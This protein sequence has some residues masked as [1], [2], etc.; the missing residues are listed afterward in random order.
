MLIT[1]V[2]HPVVLHAIDATPA[3]WRGDAVSSPLDR[4]RTAASSHPTHWLISTQ[5]AATRS[6]GTGWFY[7][8]AGACIF[9]LALFILFVVPCVI[10]DYYRLGL[11]F[12][13]D[14][15][16]ERE[17]FLTGPARDTELTD[18]RN[19]AE[20]AEGALDAAEKRAS[21]AEAKLKKLEAEMPYLKGALES[22]ERRASAAE[23]ALGAADNA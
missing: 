17:G 7:Q 12:L 1:S 3:R 16:S 10:P 14:S 22:K 23:K 13:C 19:R 5:V 9:L 4:A 8:V 6:V 11:T 2:D 21:T 18:C 15:R 20:K